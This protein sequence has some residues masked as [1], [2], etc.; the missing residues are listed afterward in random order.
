MRDKLT[1]LQ[2]RIVNNRPEIFYPL[3]D[4]EQGNFLILEFYPDH[5]IKQIGITRLTLI[6]K[7][8]KLN[9]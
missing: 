2:V 7:I 4:R 8:R 1:T 6:I 9:G 5:P 3:T